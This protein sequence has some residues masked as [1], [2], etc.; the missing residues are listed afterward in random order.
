MGSHIDLLNTHRNE[1][2]C[3]SLVG[4]NKGRKQIRAHA[5][6]QP[7]ALVWPLA[8]LVPIQFINQ[9][10]LVFFKHPPSSL[11]APETVKK[12]KKHHGCAS[13]LHVANVKIG[14]LISSKSTEDKAEVRFSVYWCLVMRSPT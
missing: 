12:E 4:E 3:R 7:Q 5:T 14:S 13:I 2:D 10:T 9:T 6:L 8:S 11:F 1:K